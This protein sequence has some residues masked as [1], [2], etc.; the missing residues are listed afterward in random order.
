MV[1]VTNALSGRLTISVD[2][3][4]GTEGHESGMIEP[5]QSWTVR[6]APG[7]YKIFASTNAPKAIA[8]LSNELLVR[9][10]EHT[11]TLTM[12]D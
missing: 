5:G 9:G 2:N 8:F 3:A 10:Y 11:W 6:L 7:V 12:P 1:S 4:Y